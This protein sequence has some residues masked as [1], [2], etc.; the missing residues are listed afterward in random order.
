MTWGGEIVKTLITANPDHQ[1]VANY[2]SPLRWGPDFPGLAGKDLSPKGLIT[3][4]HGIA[5]ESSA[6]RAAG[7]EADIPI[8]EQY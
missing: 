8:E 5:D 3:Q 4:F 6:G 1:N 2:W 7:G